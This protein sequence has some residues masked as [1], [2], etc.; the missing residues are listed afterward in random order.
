MNRH[1]APTLNIA[2]TQH[3]ASSMT[4]YMSGAAQE[5]TAP[6]RQEVA[7]RSQ[8]MKEHRGPRRASEGGTWSSAQVAC[9]HLPPADAGA[10]ASAATVARLRAAMAS[11]TA[12]STRPSNVTTTSYIRLPRLCQERVPCK[13]SACFPQGQLHWH[14]ERVCPSRSEHHPLY[15]LHHH[16]GARK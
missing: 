13:T 9:C 8:G 2:A 14:C 1:F 7:G 3:M 16:S 6:A 15:A 11:S 5:R 10:G 4:T 12:S